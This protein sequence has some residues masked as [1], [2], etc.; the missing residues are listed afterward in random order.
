MFDPAEEKVIA[1]LDWEISTV[2]DP[3]S[4]LA[5]FLFGHYNPIK[6]RVGYLKIYLMMI[7]LVVYIFISR[8]YPV[9]AT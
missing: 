8:A 1:V 7:S 6:S 9:L 4:D 3:L 5:T 2:G